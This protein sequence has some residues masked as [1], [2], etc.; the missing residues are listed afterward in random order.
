MLVLSRRCQDSI[1]FP[2]L[3]I[4][5]EI[6]QVKGSTVRVGV[7]APLEINVL[8]GELV[9]K[10]H[11]SIAKKILVSAEDE[12]KVRNSLN[13]LTIASG[14]AKKLL[15]NGK[16]RLAAS[17]LHNALAAMDVDPSVSGSSQVSSPRA[18]LVE[19]AVN[20][21]EMLA[22]FLRLHGYQVDTTGDGVEALKYLEDHDKPDFILM[23]MQL[24]NLDGP[25]AI[26]KIRQNVAFDNVEI[27]AVSGKTPRSAGVDV[28]K[29]RV[30]Q[31]F[32]KPLHPA[33]LIST[34]NSHF[35]EKEN[36]AVACG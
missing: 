29:N 23:D 8:R 11:K 10:E 24:P 13:N 4:T 27:F 3:D 6:L 19:D 7:D 33:S 32:Q 18:L 30:A 14:L 28:G 35:E 5:I 12:H 34:I 15:A 36:H 21:R 9:G 2:E 31:W 17:T 26:R 1:H 25:A 20:E 22:G 16:T